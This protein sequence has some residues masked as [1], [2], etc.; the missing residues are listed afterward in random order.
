M[1]QLTVDF[2]SIAAGNSIG[3]FTLTLDDGTILTNR[4]PVVDTDLSIDGL[5]IASVD[6]NS[7]GFFFL[8]DGDGD[9]GVVG[10]DQA[11]ARITF[12]EATIAAITAGGGIVEFAFTEFDGSISANANFRISA[13][14]FFPAGEDTDGDGIINSLDTDSDNGGC[15]LYTSDAADE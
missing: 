6:I 4:E 8:F 7:D 15:L 14:D 3:N 9:P 13:S 5:D 1:S 12:D 2:V 10:D 11:A